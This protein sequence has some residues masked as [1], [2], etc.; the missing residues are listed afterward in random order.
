MDEGRG[1]EAY[2]SGQT[3]RRLQL[4]NHCRMYLER[5]RVID[6][7][8]WPKCQSVPTTMETMF[9]CWNKGTVERWWERTTTRSCKVVHKCWRN[10]RLEAGGLLCANSSIW[11][12]SC[13]LGWG[14]ESKCQQIVRKHCKNELVGPLRRKMM[15]WF[16]DSTERLVPNGP[17]LVE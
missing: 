5:I 13:T 11:E 4:E 2:R 7:Y 17:P 9:E 8:S 6:S 15:S 10:H 14:T 16:W 1:H 3:T 12:V